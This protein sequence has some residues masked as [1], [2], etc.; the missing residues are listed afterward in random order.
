MSPF[1]CNVYLHSTAPCLLFVHNKALHIRTKYQ[2]EYVLSI[3]YFINVEG[4]NGKVN[5]MQCRR[6]L[7]K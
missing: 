4:A 2:G 3:W 7:C 1:G 6:I 5:R